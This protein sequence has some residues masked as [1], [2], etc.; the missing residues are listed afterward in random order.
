MTTARNLD[1][2]ELQ[3]FAMAAPHWWDPQ[4]DMKPLHEL[5]PLR[6]AYIAERAAL[7][8]ARVI[9]VGCGGGILSEA[10]ARRGAHVTGIEASADV[11]NIAKLHLLESQLAVDYQCITVEEYAAQATEQFDI[12][13]CMEMLEHVPDPASVIRACARLVKPGGHLFIST[14]NRHPKAFLLA[15]VGAEYVLRM[16]PRGTHHYAQ[17]IQPAELDQWLREA[18]LTLREISGVSYHPLLRRFD[19]SRDVRVN[20][21]VH[22]LK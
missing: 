15:I 10:L 19:L 14:L 21:L 11:V 5:N 7:A 9:D 17:F 6:V 20:Y 12:V 3:K 4:G 8:G 1:Q 18:E 2:T 13:T 22:A 16:L